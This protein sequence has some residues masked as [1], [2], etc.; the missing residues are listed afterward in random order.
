MLLLTCMHG[1]QGLVLPP[2]LAQA[3]YFFFFLILMGNCI[4]QNERENGKY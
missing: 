2:R 1:C 3:P 4:T